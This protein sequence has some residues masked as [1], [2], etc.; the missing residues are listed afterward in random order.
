VGPA[1]KRCSSSSVG[2]TDVMSCTDQP[3]ARHT[4]R[5]RGG[6][7]KE[8]RREGAHKH[9]E[10]HG[11]DEE[12]GLIAVAAVH[13]VSVPGARVAVVLA[14]HTRQRR[15]RKGRGGRGYVHAGPHFGGVEKA[16]GRTLLA[17]AR[18]LLW[19]MSAPEKQKETE[20]QAGGRTHRR[21]VGRNA[22]NQLDSRLH[23]DFVR[24]H[25]LPALS[26][27]AHARN[28]ERAAERR[29]GPG[30]GRPRRCRA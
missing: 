14:T 18:L 25:H 20:T 10:A 15:H 7:G 16:G 27:T 23:S 24:R 28:P 9:L 29:F 2:S 13:V 3:P 19:R 30:P 21:P 17:T 8:A 4:H 26:A 12:A 6:G 22:R 11:L 5:E 1:A